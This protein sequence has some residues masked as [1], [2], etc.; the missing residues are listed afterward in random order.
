[1]KKIAVIGICGYSVFLKGGTIPKKNESQVFKTLHTEAG[2]KGVNAAAALSKLGKN[3]SFL[4]S[5]GD[6]DNA[7]ECLKFLKAYGIYENAIIKKGA[8]TDYGV[9]LVD[10]DGGNCVSLYTG[11]SAKTSAADVENFRKEIEESDYLLMQA[12]LPNEV[13]LKAADVAAAC[14][15][16]IVFDPS[17][18]RALPRKFLEKVWLFTPNETEVDG[19]CNGF[20]PENYVVTLGEKG[21][22]V[23]E[24][25]KKTEVKAIKVKARN[26]TGA[27]DVFNA[28]LIF[29]LSDGNSLLKAVEFAVK[30][31][32]FKVHSEYVTD[33]FP[34]LKD[35]QNL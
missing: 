3:V 2:G 12:E 4:T 19:L 18:V 35:I 27:G 33:G 21:A 34:S 11:A 22:V 16:K 8:K 25:G 26:T 32:A 29:A 13:L 31:A 5:L 10:N 20:T 30:A 7:A 28:A 23:F 24:N 14:G 15:T 1:M 17:P 9:I 6:D